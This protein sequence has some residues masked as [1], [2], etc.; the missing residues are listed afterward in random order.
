MINVHLVD[1]N[2]FAKFHGIQ[3][4]SF[5]DTGKWMDG[6]TNG[7]MDNVKTVYPPTNVCGGYNQGVTLLISS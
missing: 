2:V 3:S 6:W 5:Q 7:Q 1:I 4:L